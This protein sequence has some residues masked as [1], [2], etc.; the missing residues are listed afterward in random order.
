[1]SSAPPVGDP[2][3][4]VFW[5]RFAVAMN[6]QALPAPASP[7]QAG[8]ASSQCPL[9][10]LGHV[11]QSWQRPSQMQ[12]MKGNVGDAQKGPITALAFPAR[13]IAH[14]LIFSSPACIG[15][16]HFRR[17][18]WR[19]VELPW[20]SVPHCRLQARDCRWR[21]SGDTWTYLLL[22]SRPFP[23]GRP[24]QYPSGVIAGRISGRLPEEEGSTVG[25]QL[26]G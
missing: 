21:S 3:A 10:T 1:M 2:S 25:L 23:F 16:R 5:K 15:L 14:P 18:G 4:C 22:R 20:S 12:I 26:H 13:S 6:T 11:F 24:F 8:H 9:P 17:A 19:Y 7:H